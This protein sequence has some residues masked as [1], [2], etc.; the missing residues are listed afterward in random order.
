MRPGALLV[1]A[2]RGALVDT[3]ALLDAAQQGRV[4]AALDVVDPEPLA[5]GHPLWSAPDVLITPHV[6]GSTPRF[7]DRGWRL[8]ASQAARYMRGESLLNVVSEGY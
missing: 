7:M 1:N 8:V 4:R 6:A 5:D 3:G 2:G